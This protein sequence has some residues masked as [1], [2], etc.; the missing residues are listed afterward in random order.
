MNARS[1]F[2]CLGLL[3]ACKAP[4]PAPEGLDESSRYL[5]REFYADDAVFQAG[6]QG[7][8]A[9]FADEG[10]ELLDV[11]TTIDN[12]GEFELQNLEVEDVADLPLNHGRDV[13]IAA[14]VVSL[15]VMNCGIRDSEVLLMRKDQDTLF[16]DWEGYE[17]T[18]VTPRDSYVSG[19]DD[20]FDH[21]ANPLE[22]FADGFDGSAFASTLMQTT[23]I[24][25]PSPVTLVGDFSP[26]AMHLDFRHGVYDIDGVDT[27]VFTI[28]TFI[29]DEVSGPEGTNHL[30]Q[31][32]SVEVNA[33]RGDGTTL[34][35]LAVW[36][37][38]SSDAI[39]LQPDNP[40]VLNSALNKS[41][42]ASERMTAICEGSYEIPAEP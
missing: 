21:V 42:K 29:E 36:I 38:G 19:W 4:P 34:R 40:V 18:Y 12:V 35:T 30:H 8:L 14:G 1:L 16:D 2:V 37:E 11:E 41:K 23:N 20:G 33:D 9:W 24:V 5:V 7:Y 25:D 22:P 15:A 31:S 17:R 39:D 32:Y 10:A 6:L 28:L 26:Y 3:A 27:D 13:T